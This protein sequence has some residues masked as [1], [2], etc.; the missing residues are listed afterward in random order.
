MQRSSPVIALCAAAGA[1]IATGTAARADLLISGNDEKI[2]WDD[3]GKAVNHPPGKDT[4]SII[5]IRNRTKPRIV[6]SLPLM[7]TVV[8]PPTNLA[9]TPDE[10][11][12]LVANSLDWVQ[13]GE[14]WKG[15]PD[16]KVYVIDLKASPPQQIGTVEVGKQPSG[17]AI[18][19]AGNLAL[20]AN[21]ADNSVS[22]L[23]INGN[24]VKVVDTVA[25]G[26]PGGPNEQPSAI[27]IT[28]D[29]K[30]ALV[31][32]AA[33]NKVALLEIDGQKVTYTKYDMLTGLFPYNVKITPDGR[34]AIAGNNGNSG[35]SDGQIDTAAIIDLT[36]N[37]PRVIDQVVVGDGPEGLA[38][39]PVGGYAAEIILAG[40]NAA[41][42]AFFRQ[43]HSYVSL[44]KIEGKKVRKVAQAEVG[45]LAEGAAFSP[46]GRYLYVGNFLDSD[47]TILRLQ[48]DKLTRVPGTFKLPGHPASLRGNTQ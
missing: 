2:T 27:A 40:S 17:M 38:M 5:D 42:N 11:L 6:A 20:V 37:P 15:A 46:D 13:E 45:G 25:L 30:R 43:P 9:I 22:V 41:K 48:G 8:G 26:A 35:A 14:N 36:V 7:N 18:N 31:S 16:N 1:L 12:A 24:E 32:K 10:H 23:A 21:R 33:A 4:V 34:L 29:G 19:K 44:L 47:I 39:S 3:A 28:P